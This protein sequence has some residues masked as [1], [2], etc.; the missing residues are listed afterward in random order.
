MEFSILGGV[1]SIVLSYWQFGQLNIKQPLLQERNMLKIKVYSKVELSVT[2]TGQVQKSKSGI[3]LFKLN[4]IVVSF[5]IG[6]DR[7][8]GSHSV[9]V[10]V[11][12]SV[13]DICEF[14]TQS[15]WYYAAVLEW[16]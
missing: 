8:S 3:N 14:F 13:C 16:S 4:F 1:P 9:C 5:F 12:V 2:C 15:E 10:C 7:S 11:R 6:S